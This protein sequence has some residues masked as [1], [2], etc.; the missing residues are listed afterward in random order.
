MDEIVAKLIGGNV[1]GWFQ[2]RSEL[3]PRSL[4]QRSIICDARPADMKDKLNHRVK[5]RE[6]FRPFAPIILEEDVHEW[7]DV[8]PRY[9]SSP[10]MLRVWKFRS[11]RVRQVPAVAHVDGTGRVQTVSSTTNP[12]LYSLLR[13]FKERTGVP[14]LLNT[15]FNIAGE[16][17]VE[18][19][20]DAL[21][22]MLSTGIDC[23]MLGERLVEKRLDSI[24]EL[25]PNISAVGIGIETPVVDGRVKATW[26]EP[27]SIPTHTPI[28]SSLSALEFAELQRQRWALRWVK[29]FVNTPWGAA[30]QIF[31]P[32]V[33]SIL[34]QVDGRKNGYELL[35]ELNRCG[36]NLTKES[37]TQKL[38]ILRRARVIKLL[39]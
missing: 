29:V 24:L 38:A 7:F 21:W 22:C 30:A 5:F 6:S 8:D 36:I 18:T 39:A 11:E 12:K 27:F 15:S 17:I 20:E 32:Q 37:L 10:F 35:D 4:G 31:E 3:G 14:I 2:G 9:A 25:V 28:A 26:A 16:P 1:V 19:P 33:L 13:A 34:E 23:C